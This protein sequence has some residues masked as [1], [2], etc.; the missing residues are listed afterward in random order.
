M[1]A[2]RGFWNSSR[3]ADDLRHQDAHVT[4]LLYIH[5]TILCLYFGSSSDI[6][7]FILLKMLLTDDLVTHQSGHQT[8]P[9]P[10]PPPPPPKPLTPPPPPP[11][12]PPNNEQVSCDVFLVFR[13]NKLLQQQPDCRWVETPT[14]MWRYGHEIWEHVDFNLYL[15]LRIN[16]R[17][18]P[19]RD[20]LKTDLR[21]EKFWISCTR[22]QSLNFHR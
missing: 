9:P 13:L 22:E 6:C 2:W 8:S 20:Q 21:V 3:A 7:I 18:T 16:A 10:P 12:P 4:S 1:T 17:F 19:N 14:L 11:P 15:N 5:A